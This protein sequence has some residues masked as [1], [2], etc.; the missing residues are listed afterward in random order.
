MFKLLV[1]FLR[2]LLLPRSALVLENLA[3]RHPDPSQLTNDPDFVPSNGV[4]TTTM[5]I[6]TMLMTNGTHPPTLFEP[7]GAYGYARA[8]EANA[9]GGVLEDLPP[10]KVGDGGRLRGPDEPPILARRRNLRPLVVGPD[11]T[12]RQQARGQDVRRE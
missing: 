12:A 4:A 2:S 3:L 7:D 10:R 11:R 5:T 9:Q 6:T 1:T 8:E